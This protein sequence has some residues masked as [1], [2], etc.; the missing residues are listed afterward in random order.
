MNAAPRL[1]VEVAYAAAPERQRLIALELPAGATVGEAIRASGLLAEFP[2]L[3]LPAL[4]V[5][6]Y[7]KRVPL[8]ERLR[9]GERVEIYR[10]LLA[11]P[12]Q[13]RRARAAGRRQ[14]KRG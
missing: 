11:D 10:R 7:G 4:E 3:A 1:S 14:T 13:A 12:K 5:G 6:I 2:G 9:G 8:S